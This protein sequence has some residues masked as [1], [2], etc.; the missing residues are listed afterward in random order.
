MTRTNIYTTALSVLLLQTAAARQQQQPTVAFLSHRHQ[1]Q[2]ILPFSSSSPLAASPITDEIPSD[3]TLDS[4]RTIGGGDPEAILQSRNRLIALSSTLASNSATG[5]FISRPADK[6]KLQ[7]AVNDLEALTSF[8]PPSEQMMLGDWTLIATANVPSS[9]IRRRFDKKNDNNNLLG[10]FGNKNGDNK[11][12]GLSLFGSEGRPLNPIQKSIRKSI[13]V[14]QRIR[15]DGVRTNDSSSDSN[16]INRVDN[17]IEYTPL[18]TLQDIIPKDFPLF[19]FLENLNV[20]PLQVKKSKVVLVH[21]A[22]VESVAPVLRTKIA[23]VSSVLNVAGTSQFFEPDGADV[24]GTNNP[25]GEFLNVG[26]FDTPFVDE[27][28]RI[29]RTKGPV[30]EQLRIFVRKGSNMLDSDMKDSLVAEL[31]VEEDRQIKSDIVRAE[32]QGKK[33]SEAAKNVRDAVISIGEDVSA[34]VKK[35][36]D[37]VN[38]VMG[39]AMDDVV[40]RVQ[41]VVEEDLQEIGKAI[42]GVV[43]ASEGEGFEIG[44][45]IANVTKAVTK[46]PEDVRNIVEEDVS[47]VNDAV[48]DAMDT[49]VKDVQDSVEDDLKKIES[50]IKE[51][52]GTD[53]DVGESEDDTES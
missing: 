9:D 41:D 51:V 53:E 43:Q 52:V 10:W 31:R 19:G 44:E 3:A 4:D 1:R 18:D 40:G 34:T 37:E 11:R 27:D 20:N 7:N 17:V 25:F 15:S 29:S 49:M 36:M 14:T 42:E 30:F 48:V 16:S 32:E 5:K 12:S 39:D 8:Q 26:T 46:L 24:F 35:D 21:K 23:W 50:S 13:E 28:I 33:V 6:I 45:A 22:E 47:E 2:L 38:R